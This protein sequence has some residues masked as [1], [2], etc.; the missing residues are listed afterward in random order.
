MKEKKRKKKQRKKKKK[1]LLVRDQAH[2]GKQQ[3]QEKYKENV[4]PF[5]VKLGSFYYKNARKV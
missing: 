4:N 3:G 1:D 5:W 2:P